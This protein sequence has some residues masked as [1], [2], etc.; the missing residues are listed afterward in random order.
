MEA[1]QREE[2]M[3]KIREVRKR[4]NRIVPF[5]KAKIEDA[6]YAAFRSVGEG[7]RPLAAEL[8]DAVT[9]FLESKYQGPVPGIEDIQDVV[10]TVLI[11][12]GHTRVAKA[13]ILYRQK[14]ATLRETLQVRKMGHASD[15]VA[16]EECAEDAWSGTEAGS[17]PGVD[18]YLP[19]VDQ[20]V[21][22]IAPWRKSRIAAALIREADLDARVAEEI[23]STVERKV[24]DSG[25]RRISTSLI[26]EL[27]D[28][29]LFERGFSAKL[30]KQ[31]PIS[32][33]RYNLEQIIFGMD[34]KEG[35]AFPK[36]PVE[37]RNIIA[38]RILLQYSLGEVFTPPVAYAHGEGRMFIHRLSDPIRVARIRWHLH[39]PGEGA[40]GAGV[41]SGS[42]SP[43]AYF[44]L[45]DFFR[46]VWHLA[47][48]VSE[49]V[50][51]SGLPNVLSG[52]GSPGDAVRAFLERLSQMEERPDTALELDLAPGVLP[53]LHG[54]VELARVRPRR[55]LISLSLDAELFRSPEAE[56]VL[57]CVAGLFEQ[58]ERIEFLPARSL[59]SRQG[60]GE[61]GLE[62]SRLRLQQR[63]AP[64]LLAEVGKVTLNL[65]RAAFR[66]GRDLR[67]SMDS[68]IEEIVHLAVRGHLERRQF[69][70]RLSA[71]RESPLWDL[72]SGGEGHAWVSGRDLVFCVGV[73]GLNECVKYLTGS[74]LHQDPSA[75]GFGLRIMQEIQR[76]LR[77]E[78]RSLG[79]RL[80]LEE[81]L[82]VGPLRILESADR[83]RCAQIAEV[84][85]GR[86]A[87]WGAAYSNGVRFHRMAPVD[88][89]RRVEELTRY[90]GLLEPA[91][92]IVEDFPELRSSAGDL[93]SSLLEECVPLVGG[94]SYAVAS[95]SVEH[96]VDRDDA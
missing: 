40:A 93:L 2:A 96:G 14:R 48:F 13:Y 11:E 17:A 25:L 29:E 89:F 30:Q 1:V 82:N 47:Q 85:R 8:A 54:L 27:V 20:V 79:V 81:T 10:E 26:R 39:R 84:D 87:Q 23:A 92:G 91:G 28:N 12:F 42:V 58:G 37:I 90:L 62:G 53:W 32:L 44:D 78:E 34:R 45:G 61:P 16:A 55:F 3:R 7:D 15:P 76:R 49:E 63:R 46:R 94:G 50:R 21:E 51:L 35:F 95:R 88:P 31:A 59:D 57:R 64:R 86:N 69:V 60:S 22:G 83:R 24:L 73:L 66:S 71:H 43:A 67:T 4:D 38:N 33:P 6:I 77:T 75:T 80:A 5:D 74:E 72:L 36:T 56:S 41:S 52:S 68:E 9:H 18:R 65:P 19:E 70:E